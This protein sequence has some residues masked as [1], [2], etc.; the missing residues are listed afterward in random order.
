MAGLVKVLVTRFQVSEVSPEWVTKLS[1]ELYLK[2]VTT[3]VIPVFGYTK[4][5]RVFLAAEAVFNPV[6]A[7]YAD[8]NPCAPPEVN[9]ND[10]NP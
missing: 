7:V 2:F 3:D 1:I 5:D 8:T 6:M 9:L 10:F 4:K